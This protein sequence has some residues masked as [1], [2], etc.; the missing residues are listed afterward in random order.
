MGRKPALPIGYQ[1]LSLAST[2]QRKMYSTPLIPENVLNLMGIPP[3]TSLTS[4]I[5]SDN[6]RTLYGAAKTGIHWQSEELGTRHQ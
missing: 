6:G 5:I 3:F 4:V 2:T 1:I